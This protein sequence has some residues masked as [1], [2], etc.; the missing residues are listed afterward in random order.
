[1]PS[2]G[3]TLINVQIVRRDDSALIAAANFGQKAFF[4]HIPEQLMIKNQYSRLCPGSKLGQFLRGCVEMR[5]ILLPRGSPRR[6]AGLRIDFVNQHI[7]LFAV[8]DDAAGRCG[9]TEITIVR[10]GVSNR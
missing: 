6:K 8:F 5:M 4:G 1:M 9:I 3:E 10:S 2:Q 7:T